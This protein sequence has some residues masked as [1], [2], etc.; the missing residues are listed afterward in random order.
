MLPWR[1]GLGAGTAE[2]LAVNK[3]IEN[4]P[5]SGAVPG[6][7]SSSRGNPGPFSPTTGSGSSSLQ[8]QNET[9]KA[10]RA[11]DSRPCPPGISGS[12]ALSFLCSGKRQ[13]AR[14]LKRYSPTLPAGFWAG[15]SRAHPVE[16]GPFCWGCGGRGHVLPDS[17]A[18]LLFPLYLCES[19]K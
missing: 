18:L 12:P 4:E 16:Q 13:L 15:F 17:S 8:R 14:D 11:Q 2:A 6:L 9:L 10:E 1:R 3:C 7:Y 19:L 5:Q